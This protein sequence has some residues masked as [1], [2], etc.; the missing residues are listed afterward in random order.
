MAG[1]AH[2]NVACEA[3]HVRIL[4]GYEMTS[5][6]PGKILSKPNP[7]KKYSLY[8]GPQ[9]PPS[10]QIRTTMDTGKDLASAGA[11][12]P[13]RPYRLPSAGQRARR[14]IR[15]HCSA[16]S[17]S[18]AGTIIISPGSRPTRWRTHSGNRVPAEAATT[19]RPRSRV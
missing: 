5:W 11:E 14:G 13:L 18:R 10:D 17:A 19:L 1:G 2:K 12:R 8:Y 9:E 6:G 7:F 4:G 3:C 15:T 16:P